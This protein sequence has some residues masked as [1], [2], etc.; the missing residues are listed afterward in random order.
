MTLLIRRF[1]D[2]SKIAYSG[3]FSSSLDVVIAD[4]DG[5][6]PRVWRKTP[7][8][9][10]YDIAWSSDGRRI[11]FT[12]SDRVGHRVVVGRVDGRS[13]HVVPR[14]NRYIDT[15][16]AWRPARPF[17]KVRRRRC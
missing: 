12:R 10:E 1:P 15:D 6:N 7:A 2:G 9:D 17:P 16:P 13:Q 3:V 8:G 11:A 14:S 4:A 5:G